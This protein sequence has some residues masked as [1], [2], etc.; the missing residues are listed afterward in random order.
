MS[1]LERDHNT[2]MNALMSRVLESS[3]DIVVA[4]EASKLVAHLA[5]TDPELLRGWLAVNAE[6]F[7]ADT[8]GSRLR[9]KRGYVR[10][11]STAR[12]F[13]V[14]ARSGDLAALHPFR[15]RH[16]V[17]DRYT[18]RAVGKMDGNDHLFVAQSY[19]LSAQTSQMLAAFHRA[20]AR[21]VGDRKTEEVMDEDTYLRMYESIVRGD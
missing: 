21:R 13:A 4:V 14:A 16:I 5:E 10:R 17:D 19:D 9:S 3:D 8:L 11:T 7:V 20:V 1:S 18:Q 6:Q 15:T 12:A 2:E